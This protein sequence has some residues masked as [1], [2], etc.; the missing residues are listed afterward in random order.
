VDDLPVPNNLDFL[1]LLNNTFRD[2]ATGDRFCAPTSELN[3]ED[4]KNR[5]LARDAFLVNGWE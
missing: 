2:A 3:I 5:C 1:A 4:L